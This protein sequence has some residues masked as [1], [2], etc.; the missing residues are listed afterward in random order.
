MLNIV[1]SC[2]QSSEI[3]CQPRSEVMYFGCPKW[4]NHSE[5]GALAQD[6]AVMSTIGM[7]S[8]RVKQSMMVKR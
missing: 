6:S 3:N 5:C 4:E 8:G 7:T 1:S 2:F